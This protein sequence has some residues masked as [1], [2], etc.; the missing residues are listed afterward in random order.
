MVRSSYMQELLELVESRAREAKNW[1]YAILDRITVENLQHSGFSEFETYGNFLQARHPES[2]RPRPLR[3]TR[4][5]AA[6]FGMSP[7]RCDV[8]YLMKR[9]Y[10]FASFERWNRKTGWRL[11]P[12]KI[13]SLAAYGAAAVAASALRREINELALANMI[14][15]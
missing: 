8:Y 1:V 3:S 14:C 15:R 7:N 9:G 11:W 4:D 12:N 2:F 10:C 6:L 5:A 13:T